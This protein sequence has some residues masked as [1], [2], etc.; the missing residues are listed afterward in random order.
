MSCQVELAGKIMTK[1]FV[2][3]LSHFLKLK[4]ITDKVL[5]QQR[6]FSCQFLSL[7]LSSLPKNPPNCYFIGDLRA[8]E[9]PIGYFTYWQKVRA[10]FLFADGACFWRQT[11]FKIWKFSEREYFLSPHSSIAKVTWPQ[12]V[13]QR[14]WMVLFIWNKSAIN[15]QTWSGENVLL[16][17]KAIFILMHWEINVK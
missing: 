15:T 3:E 7:L 12:G 6:V 14:D 8:V 17:G 1:Q 5:L 16:Y 2:S 11:D 10:L 9:K 13:L 4:F